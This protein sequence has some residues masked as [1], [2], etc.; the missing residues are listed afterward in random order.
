M[1]A[2]I[3]GIF[4]VL[5]GCIAAKSMVCDDGSLALPESISTHGGKLL[6]M[7]SCPAGP[8]SSSGGSGNATDVIRTLGKE[9]LDLCATSCTTHCKKSG[10]AGPIASDCLTLAD[11]YAKS[12]R[13]V[14]KHGRY[15]IWA[16]QTCKITQF[17]HL[18]RDISY[19][20][21]RHNWAGIVDHIAERCEAKKGR[22]GGSCDFFDDSRS[23]RIVVVPVDPGVLLR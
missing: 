20:Y 8:V 19:C 23:S 2:A 6:G 22:L 15:I 18:H 3:L 5:A 21:D 10:D 13:F 1:R 9:T 14:I 7:W 4:L 11:Y 16:Y 12:G 17:N